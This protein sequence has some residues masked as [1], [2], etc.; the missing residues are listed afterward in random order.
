[1]KSIKCIWLFLKNKI[2]T[3]QDID[4]Y[5]HL[6]SAGPNLGLYDSLTEHCE[7]NLIQNGRE[8]DA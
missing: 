1:M 4:R 3:P 7:L 8:I 6:I 5:R 2:F